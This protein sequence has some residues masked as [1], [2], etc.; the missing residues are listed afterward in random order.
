M[1]DSLSTTVAQFSSTGG[2]AQSRAANV[3][4]VEPAADLPGADRGN[5]YVLV[6]VTGTGGGHSALYRQI[7][8][9]AQTAF[10]EASGNMSAALARAVRSAHAVLA[11]ANEVLAEANWRAGMSCVA[12]QGDQLTIAQAGPCLVMVSHPKTIDQY[13]AKPGPA[14]VALGGPDRPEVEV[15]RTTVEPGSIVLLA[16]SDWLKSVS[17]ESLAAVTA[18]ESVRLASDY[19]MQLAGRADL[20]ALLISFSTEIPEV[21]DEVFAAPAVVTTAVTSAVPVSPT[22]HVDEPARQATAAQAAVDVPV[23]APA[24]RRPPRKAARETPAQPE[25]HAAGPAPEVEERGRRSPW[26]LVLALVVIPLIILAVV[27]GMWWFNARRA[28]AQFQQILT[29]AETAIADA[30]GLPDEAQAR[31]RLGNAHDFIESARTLRPN[32]PQLAKVQATYGD[33]LGKVNRITPLYGLL[34]LRQFMETGRKLDRVLA[35]GDSLYVLDRGKHEVLRFI[36][37]KLEDSVTPAEPAEIIRKGQAVGTTAVS[38]LVDADWSAAVG[39]QRSRLLALDTAGGLVGYDVTWGAA[40]LPMT[41][42]DKVGLPQLI[43]SYGGN[44]Y[45]VDTK[46]NQIW[47]FRP[48]EKGYENQPEAYFLATTKVDLAGVQ[49]IDIDGNVWL[50]FADGR[51]LKFFGGEQKAFEL[52]GLPD[53]MSAPMAIASQADGDLI[54]I[55]DSGNGRI[56]EFSKEGQF[57]RQFRPP[58]GDALQGMRDLFL[59]ETGAKFYI[60]TG[61]KLWRADI[62]RV[63]AAAKPATSN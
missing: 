25:A 45:V 10:Y 63:P 42:R 13:P 32:D 7:L 58:Q 14:G 34:D 3:R 52:K 49:S 5:L 2:R 6:E 18:A 36:L 16:Q 21:Q 15:Y 44:L 50:L 48:S 17:P 29:G 37:S 53:P 19:L 24:G 43:K 47:R 4:A 1:S 12:I 11:R 51:L 38:D 28:D 35:G 54:Y 55:A 61:D 27:G 26:W 23:A 31:L 62:P 8:N 40:R 39:N 20:S 46:N 60:V 30:Q 59:D 56:L 22:V 33:V 9:A 57:Q 41:G